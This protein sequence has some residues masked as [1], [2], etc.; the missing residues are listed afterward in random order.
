M[1]PMIVRF[2]STPTAVR[3]NCATLSIQNSKKVAIASGSLS[4]IFAICLIL[5]C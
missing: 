5:N 3:E 2:I 4:F 1:I